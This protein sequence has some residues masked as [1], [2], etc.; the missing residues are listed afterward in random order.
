[1]A[2]KAGK[3]KFEI[4]TKK[5]GKWVMHNLKLIG[6]LALMA[7]SWYSAKACN[8]TNNFLAFWFGA[9]SVFFAIGGIL[10]LGKLACDLGIISLDS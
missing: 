6:A 3:M 2:R 10:S 8:E 9:I 1:M 5:I 7:V 4:D